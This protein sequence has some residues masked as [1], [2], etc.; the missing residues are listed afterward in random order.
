MNQWK[1]DE[2]LRDEQADEEVVTVDKADEEVVTNDKS[3]E[4]VVADDKAD[5]HEMPVLIYSDDDEKIEEIEPHVGL[6]VVARR[7]SSQQNCVDDMAH[8]ENIF[9]TKCHVKD[10]VLQWFNETDIVNVTKQPMIPFRIGKFEDEVLCNVVPMETS[11]IWLERQQML[12]QNEEE[13]LKSKEKKVEVK[14]KGVVINSCCFGKAS[15]FKLV[16]H[17]EWPLILFWYKESTN[18]SYTLPPSISSILQE[19]DDIFSK[20]VMMKEFRKLVFE[21]GGWVWLHMCKKRFPLQR[22]LKLLPRGDG[23]FQVLE[24]IN[25][26]A[27]KLDL[28][29]E[30]NVSATFNVADLSP[31]AVGDDLDLRTNPLQEEGNDGIQGSLI[32]DPVRVPIGPVTR[33]RAKKFKEALQGLIQEVWAQ[34]LMKKP[35]GDGGS[36]SPRIITLL[37]YSG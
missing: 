15:D 34:E 17:E 31:F 36:G 35:I 28:S 21:P 26:N 2:Q 33:A 27:Y 3:D 19:F 1:T 11:Y 13:T 10:K 8:G 23:L 12:L 6:T 7:S 37:G 9:H 4:E 22:H 14:E 32:G 24:R 18:D 5:D 29:G 25:D 16:V 30:Y 20:V